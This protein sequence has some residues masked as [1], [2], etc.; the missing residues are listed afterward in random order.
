MGCF[1]CEN[2][3]LSIA[4][5]RHERRALEEDL[6]ASVEKLVDRFE[7]RTGLQ[8][9]AIEVPMVKSAVG[10]GEFGSEATYKVGRCMARVSL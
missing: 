1:M 7:R 5:M 8:V 4:G 3:Q 2:K 9:G 6:R 10:S